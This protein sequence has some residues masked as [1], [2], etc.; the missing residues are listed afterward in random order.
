M[1][2]RIV[3]DL[4]KY[5]TIKHHVPGRIRLKF[6]MK[7]LADPRARELKEETSDKTPPPCIKDT[8]LNLLART[9]II[10]YDPEVLEPEKLHEA[11]TTTDE[12]RF[13]EL[14]TE[15]ET[16]LAV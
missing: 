16:V 13:K 9:V 12:K 1:D 7:L 6:G 8:K 2:F 10:D 3:M 14:A 15:L 11:L 5:L 4:R